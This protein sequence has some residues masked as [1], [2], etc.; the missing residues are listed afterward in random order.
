MTDNKQKFIENILL[1]NDSKIKNI[2]LRY[3]KCDSDRE[4]IKQDVLVKIWK[5]A[6]SLNEEANIGAWISKVTVNQCKNFL[7]GHN[8]YNVISI[9]NNAEDEENLLE[10]I[11]DKIPAPEALFL[12]EEKQKIVLD[13]IE[14]LPSKLRD[15]TILYDFEDLSYEQIA[16]KVNCPVGTIKSRLFRARNILKENLKIF[17]S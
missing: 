12:S 13:A 11:P 9:H 14:K 2:I 17:N 6:S 3:I 7:R 16:V 15:V 5:N 4:D 1:K 10:K 8:K